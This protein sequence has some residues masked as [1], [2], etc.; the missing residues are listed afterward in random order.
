MRLTKSALTVAT[1]SILEVGESRG[2]LDKKFLR[3]LAVSP[4][5]GE[6]QLVILTER[7]RAP[8]LIHEKRSSVSTVRFKSL[9]C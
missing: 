9:D 7:A 3:R 4:V 5:K 1:S 6:D 2:C 8:S